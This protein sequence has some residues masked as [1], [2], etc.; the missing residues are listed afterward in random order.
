[1]EFAANLILLLSSPQILRFICFPPF[2]SPLFSSPLL[3]SP[4]ETSFFSSPLLSSPQETSFYSSPLLSSPQ[5]TS[6][7]SSPLLLSPPL[8]SLSRSCSLHKFPAFPR[9]SVHPCLRIRR[10]SSRG[11]TRGGADVD[12]WRG[13]RMHRRQQHNE[14]FVCAG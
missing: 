8:P 10:R 6:F 12:K 7:Y 5:E 14:M 13:R 3:S 4:Q 2:F 9:Q 11:G 1:M